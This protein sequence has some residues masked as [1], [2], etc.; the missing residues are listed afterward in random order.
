MGERNPLLKSHIPSD[1]IYEEILWILKLN[2]EEHARLFLGEA[3]HF[4]LFF[5][6]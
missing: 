5:S 4:F 3:V 2:F 6:L 1:E